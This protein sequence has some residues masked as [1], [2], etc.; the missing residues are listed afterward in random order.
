MMIT[1][2]PNARVCVVGNATSIMAKKNGHLIDDF[3]IVVRINRGVIRDAASQGS[4]TT[5]L[6][7]GCDLTEGEIEHFGKPKLIEFYRLNHKH[8]H[9]IPEEYRET[10]DYYPAE[11]CA[12]LQKELGAR[13][14]TGTMAIELM[15][16]LRPKEVS[17]FG[18]DYK[19]SRT[20]YHTGSYEHMGPHNWIAESEWAKTNVTGMIY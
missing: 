7:Y 1:I 5:I 11:R 8:R 13:P 9:N 2:P 10:I 19:K 3:D 18:F 15:L 14:S 16:S 20:F 6:G 4:K 12:A 17:V